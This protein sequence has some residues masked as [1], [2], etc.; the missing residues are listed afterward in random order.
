MEATY[1]ENAELLSAQKN[2]SSKLLYKIRNPITFK[3]AQSSEK[4][5]YFRG[6]RQR[7]FQNYLFKRVSKTELTKLISR[8]Q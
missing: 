3:K 6:N 5:S 7:K 2:F 4:S 1:R 8:S